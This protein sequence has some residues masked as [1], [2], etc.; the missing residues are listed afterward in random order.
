M[1]AEVLAKAVRRSLLTQGH[2]SFTFTGV[3]FDRL[4]RDQSRLN[5]LERRANM[6]GRVHV[7]PGSEFRLGGSR[8]ILVDDIV[9]TGSTLR[10]VALALEESGL[11]PEIFLS[12]AETL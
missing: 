8:V 1:P 3:T 12:F 9:T 10:N 2:A 6:D 7:K 5:A 11:K 4:V